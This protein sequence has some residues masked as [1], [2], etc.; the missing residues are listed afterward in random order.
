[1]WALTSVQGGHG[2]EQ[3]AEEYVG[4]HCAMEFGE[5]RVGYSVFNWLQARIDLNY[6]NNTTHAHAVTKITTPN[7]PAE[8][9]CRFRFWT[10]STLV[11]IKHCRYYICVWS[12]DPSTNQLLNQDKLI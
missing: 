9:R 1:M 8:Q 11:N 3:R 5:I 6:H 4:V 10:K 2:N 7:A 12:A